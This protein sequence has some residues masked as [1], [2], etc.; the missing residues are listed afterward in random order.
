MTLTELYQILKSTGYPVTYSHFNTPPTPPYVCYLVSY[1]PN[2]QAD[3]KVYKKIDNVQ[4]ELYT[5]KKDLSAE[6]TLESVLDTNGIPYES[7]ETYIESEQ[8]FQIIYEVRLI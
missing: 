8:L 3:N 1:S 4:I 6:S 7:T 2:F 5:N